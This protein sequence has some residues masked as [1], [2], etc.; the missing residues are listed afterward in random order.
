MGASTW[1]RVLSCPITPVPSVARLC[2][3]DGN[4]SAKDAV[5]CPDRGDGAPGER[6]DI[7]GGGA[8]AEAPCSPGVRWGDAAEVREATLAKERGA[9]ESRERERIVGEGRMATLSAGA[10]VG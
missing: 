6:I 2:K 7:E 1:I 3:P 9:G 4:P 5:P 10:E 8:D